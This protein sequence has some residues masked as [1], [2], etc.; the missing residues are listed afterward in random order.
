MQSSRLQ[1]SLIPFNMLFWKGPLKGAFPDIYLITFFGLHNFAN[2]SPM[3]VILFFCKSSKFNV[4][5]RNAEKTSEKV[6]CF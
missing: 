2:T 5:F 6:F 1:Q 3:R 4:D